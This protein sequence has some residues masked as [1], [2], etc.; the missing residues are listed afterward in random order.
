LI[1]LGHLPF[2]EGKQA[3]WIRRGEVVGETGRKGE[4]GN[5]GQDIIHERR[6]N[7]TIKKKKD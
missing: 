5:C 1:A 4:R 7:K 3:E 6:V 2:S